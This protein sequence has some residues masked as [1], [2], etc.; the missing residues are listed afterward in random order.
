MVTD[1]TVDMATVIYCKTQHAIFWPL[2]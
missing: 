1:Y 2:L